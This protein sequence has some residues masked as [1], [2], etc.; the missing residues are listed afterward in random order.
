MGLYRRGNGKN[1]HIEIV[2][3]GERLRKS[4]GTSDKAL[5]QCVEDQ[6]RRELLEDRIGIK[7]VP[8]VAWMHEKWLKGHQHFTAKH[9]ETTKSQFRLHILPVM[10]NKL[11]T[12]VDNELM[13]EL[14]TEFAAT[15]AP[16]TTKALI[17]HIT[18]MMHYAIE[19]GYI[20]K[21]PYKIEK[22]VVPERVRPFLRLEDMEKLVNTVRA[23]LL[24]CTDKRRTAL[25]HILCM[26]QM[27]EY[28]GM[29]SDEVRISTWE[30]LDL[31]R[32]TY[33]IPGDEAKAHTTRVI[34]LPDCLIS[35]IQTMLERTDSPYLFPSSDKR[36][37]GQP[38]SELFFYQSLNG[39]QGRGGKRY[40]GL[41]QKAGLP[42]MG[43]HRLRA[44]YATNSMITG[45]SPRD[46][47]AVGGWKNL[48]T[49]EIYL[50]PNVQLH[51]SNVN[52]LVSFAQ[53]P[54]QSTE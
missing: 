29:R 49:L 5:A 42:R 11:L 25:I 24:T 27:A 16:E 17:R 4:T 39:Y 10:G 53:N 47:M 34:G 33:T 37:K 2:H 43:V 22:V 13:T 52:R 41:L 32:G 9:L 50:E 18:T 20:Q 46:L 36:L 54:P 21:M 23:L 8:T 51:R 44:S 38:R 45:T 1:W 35:D 3:D 14:R 12:A 26:V 6:W 28:C 19:L 48:K 15:H 7:K 31:K 30:R 40:P